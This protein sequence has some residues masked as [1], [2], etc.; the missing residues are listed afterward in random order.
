MRKRT[1]FRIGWVI[2][3]Q[4]EKMP[5]FPRIDTGV[6][7]ISLARMHWIA[8]RIN[9]SSKNRLHYEVYKPWK[10][11]DGLIF[12]KAMGEKSERLA[13]RYLRQDRPVIFDAN[14]NYY[15][16]FGVEH[17]QGMLPTPVQR[18]QAVTL[19]REVTAVI[20]DSRY[21]AKE[22]Q[23]LNDNVVWIPDNVETGIVPPFLNRVRSKPLRMVWC[24]EAIKL[25]ELLVIE[26]VLRA[27]SKH[28]QL[29]LITG[30]LSAS[31][32]WKKNYKARIDKLL[33]DIGALLIPFQGAH[34]LL[35]QYQNSDVVLSP[36]F[37]DNSY[38]LGHTEWKITLAMACGCVAVASPIPS[39]EEVRKR[40]S[41]E[42]ITLCNTKEEWCQAFEN[43]LVEGV[44]ND[45]REMAMIVVDKHYSSRVVAETHS[46]F[47]ERLL[48]DHT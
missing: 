42:A 13:R 3:D 8:Q 32:R 34:A 6:G 44:R 41:D 7:G 40:S 18:D 4:L 14:V 16:T 47:L 48:D 38:N 45:S 19:T 31:S 30:D 46:R 37:L 23:S 21:I 1:K 2:T 20:A 35:N 28:C 11:F 36:R 5:Y 25:F 24:G 12:L 27:F 17:Y 33:D 9:G 26:D 10:H 29:I 15:T 39:Y 43:L 22:C